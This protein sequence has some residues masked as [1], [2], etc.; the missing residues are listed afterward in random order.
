MTIRSTTKTEIVYNDISN[1]YTELN[2]IRR[3]RKA[4]RL[5][6]ESYLFK[7]QQLTETM[8]VEY[9]EMTGLKWE[10]S[11][12]KGWNIYTTALKKI[13]NTAAHG[14]P[15]ILYD[16]V[17]SVYPNVNFSLDRYNKT[18]LLDQGRGFRLVQTRTFKSNPLRSDVQSANTAFLNKNNNYVYLI[19]EFIFYELRLDMMGIKRLDDYQIFRIDVMM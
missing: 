7:S 13:R 18:D 8:R 5:A 19:K 17:L 4:F 12:F 1:L 16:F 11:K 15:I 6:F 3:N 14:Y 9:R 2:N 10:A